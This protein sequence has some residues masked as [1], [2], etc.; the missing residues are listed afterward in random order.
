MP[1]HL[2][3]SDLKAQLLRYLESAGPSSTET[4]CKQLNVSQPVFSRLVS[5][6]RNDV[7]VMGQARATRYAAKRIIPDIGNQFLLH[8]IDTKGKIVDLGLLHVL[9]P[10]GFYF[11]SHVEVIKSQLFDDL[12]YF[13]DDL[14]PAGFLGRL[15]PQQYP[16]L[17]APSDIRSWSANDCLRFLTQYGWDM[18]GSLLV[19]NESLQQCLEHS[20]QNA[21]D[22]IATKDRKKK[23]TELAKNILQL[24][25]AGSSAAGEHPKFLATTQD[26]GHV[27]VKF[28]PPLDNRLA[29]RRADLLVCE[30]IAH[31]VLK[32][33]R[34]PS[35]ASCLIQRSDRLF[36][37][38]VR[39]DRSSAGRRGTISLNALNLEFVGSAGGWCEVA[40][41]LFDQRLIDKTAHQQILWLDLFGR[42][43]L[44]TDRH[45]GNIS[46]FTENLRVTSLAPVYDMLPMFFAPQNEQILDRN[47]PSV[48][49]Q[50]HDREVWK[51]AWLAAQEFW[52][53]VSSHKIISNEFKK[54]ADQAQRHVVAAKKMFEKI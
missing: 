33:F 23:Y 8:E 49:P 48:Q 11:E 21:G 53:Q 24:G 54:I 18:V 36:L 1:K 16:Q 6:M 34:V 20:N 43:I 37:E 9:H 42:L 35:A 19:G 14:R 51:S 44:N 31:Q 3:H 39:F 15:V 47:L 17:R 10:K 29:Q 12:P 41:R 46:F 38:I 22:V 25:P 30:H 27:L 7:L 2:K 40:Q 45:L 28:T 5:Q 26:R 32:K 4:L 13:L 50:M 52:K